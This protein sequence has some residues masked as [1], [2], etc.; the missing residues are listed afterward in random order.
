MDS[1]SRARSGRWIYS[2]LPIN[3]AIGPVSTFAQLYILELHGSVLDIGLASTLFAAASIPAAI[4][5]GFVTDRIHTRKALVVWS[6]VLIAGILFSF[7]FVRTVYG[8]IVVYSAFSFLSSAFATPLNLLIMETQ[9][10]ASWASA[11]ARFSMISSVGVTVGL[12]L[13]VGWADFL[14]FHLLVIA[15]GALS[16]VSAGLSVQMIKEPVTVFERSMI[17][18]VSQSFYQLILALPM[19]FL[20][21][22]TLIDFRRVFRSVK[23]GLTREPAL[24]YLSIGAFY[25]ASGLFN[26]S[27][28][29][30]LYSA[31]VTKSEV[32]SVL[33]VGMIVQVFAFNYIGK[34]I[35][36][37]GIRR[38]AVQGLVLRAFSYTGFAIAVLY[39]AGLPYLGA[40]L[41][42]YPLGAGI[43]Y[44]YYY[45]ASNVMVFNT[46]GRTNQGSSL[47]VYSAVV[48]QATMVGSFI[49]GLLSFYVGYYATYI[50]AALWLG[51]AAS[52]T[53]AI[54]EQVESS[55]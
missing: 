10:K 52:L 28:V 11:F 55:Q 50:A 23:F 15:L 19:L 13:S 43:A 7:V 25:F 29:P 44:A 36:V 2:V 33:L 21:I 46:L 41:F 31:R 3:M 27:L 38:T 32:F 26:T 40:A 9:P 12:L 39:L 4:F 5:W 6:Y 17:V 53:S 30:S 48:G 24:I 8:I 16:L 45:A 18:M 49:S 22:P 42:F 47:G 1:A 35:R 20:K 54:G 14:P 51:L 34:R 37:T